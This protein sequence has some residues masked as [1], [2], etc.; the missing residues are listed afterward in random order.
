T[1]TDAVGEASSGS[2][3][4]DDAAWAEGDAASEAEDA[5]HLG[6]VCLLPDGRGL[7]LRPYPAPRGSWYQVVGTGP[8]GELEL[9][10]SGGNVLTFDAR[11]IEHLEVRVL[12]AR[13]SGL[14][15]V[16]DRVT[17]LLGGRPAATADGLG[18]GVTVARVR[19]P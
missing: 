4:W 3:A 15:G 8:E 11:G 12:D 19:L 7:V 17:T 18:D 9:A 6:V 1:P 14:A 2:D 10:R 13:R 16:L 5:G